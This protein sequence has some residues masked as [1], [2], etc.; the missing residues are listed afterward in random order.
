[1]KLNLILNKTSGHSLKSW[2]PLAWGLAFILFMPIFSLF[3]EA[4]SAN[5]ENLSHYWH[6]VLFTYIQNSLILLIGV[7]VLVVIWGVPSAYLVSRYQFLGRRIFRWAL[8][9]PMALP[10]Y[11]VAFVYTSFLDYAG[12]LQ[13][14]LRQVFDWHSANDYWFVD[15]RTMGGAIFILSLVFYPYVY[16]LTSINFSEQSMSLIDA[17]RLQGKSNFRIF[18]HVQLPLA[19]PAIAVACTLVAMETLADYGTVAYFS[20]WHITTAV[21]KSWIELGDLPLASKLS[22]LMLFFVVILITLERYSRRRMRYDASHHQPIIL[23]KLSGWRSALAF[24]WCALILLLSFLLPCL[25]LL[26]EARIYF[27]DTDWDAFWQLSRQTFSLAL[28]VATIAVILAF[29]QQSIYRVYPR[30]GRWL[31]RLSSLGYA[32]PGTILAIGVLIMTTTLDHGINDALEYYGFET[33]GLV[34]SGTLVAMAIAF[35]CRFSAVALGSVEVGF[36]KIPKSYDEASLLHGHHMASTARKVWLPLLRSSL[37]TAFLLVFLESLKELSAALLLRPFNVETL[38]TY[39][40]QY[41]E[42]ERFEQAAIPAILI[43]LIGLPP[44]L[45]LT[46]SM[47][48]RK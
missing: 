11:L 35:L 43:I 14:F 40:Y 23:E 42:S 5:S 26:N 37:L 6:T 34:L 39:I 32:I 1:M 45:L 38:S 7:S 2:L 25:W 33:I 47:E 41:M 44:V 28:I 48:K 30:Q 15:M 46:Y 13:I 4:L 17:A 20:V 3:A 29:I 24:S 8:L 36:N 31:V 21:Y 16:W 12:P 22:C 18:W 9:L 10:A 27:G 19:R